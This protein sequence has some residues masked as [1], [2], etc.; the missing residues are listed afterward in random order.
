VYARQV[1]IKISTKGKKMVQVS[2]KAIEQIDHYLTIEDVI[3]ILKISRSQFW[4]LRRAGK[5][6]PPVIEAPIRW[7][8]TDIVK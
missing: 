3:S 8:R 7:R 1:L 6:P 2:Q 4:R 5:I